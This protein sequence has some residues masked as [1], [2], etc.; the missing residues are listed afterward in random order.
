MA[1]IRPMHRTDVAACLGLSRQAGWNQIE[2]DW[3][4]SLDLGGPGNFVAERRSEVVGSVTTCRFGL[5]GWVGMLLVERSLRGEGIGRNLLNRAIAHLEQIGARS[6]RLDATPLGRPLYESLGFRVDF[7]LA[8][9]AGMLATPR[10]G[11]TAEGDLP[12]DT[13]AIVEFDREVTRT[14]RGPLIARLLRDAPGSCRVFRSAAGELGGYVLWREGANAAQIGPCAGDA[15]AGRILLDAAAF[16][17]AGRPVFIDLAADHKPSVN[18]AESAGLR[19][20]RP[21]W[22]MTRGEPIIIEDVTRLWASSG[23]EMG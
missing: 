21:F 16:A 18:W 19:P 15:E 1:T 20:A 6:I 11:G 10:L 17:L 3:L 12:G 14:E 9:F 22:R 4:R 23:P 7:E 2:A 8:R 5:I 13:A